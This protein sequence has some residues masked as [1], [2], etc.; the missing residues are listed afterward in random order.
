MSRSSIRVLRR[1]GAI[2]ALV[3]SLVA[4]PSVAQASPSASDPASAPS[5][6][7]SATSPAPAVQPT[8]TGSATGGRAPAPTSPAPGGPGDA[9]SPSDGAQDPAPSGWVGEGAER[10]YI[11]PK[12]RK[13]VVDEVREID[14]TIYVFDAKG[15]VPNGWA[16]SADGTVRYSTPTGVRLGWLSSGG[17][18]YYLDPGA[19]GARTTGLRD[20]AGARYFFDDE[21]RMATGWAQAPDGWYFFETSGAARSGWLAQSGAW[22]YLDPASSGRM[23]TGWRAIGGSWYFLRANG[24]MATGWLSQGATWYHLA[25]SGAMTTGWLSQGDVWYL[26]DP[27]GAMATGWRAIGGSWYFLRANGAMATGW[28]SQGATWYHL[29]PS[30]TMTTGWLSQ[31]G[32]W[33][34]LEGDGAMSTGWRVVSGS[35]NYFDRWSGRWVTDRASFQTDWDRAKSVYSPTNS[36]IVV[37]TAAPHCTSFYWGDGGWQPQND[38]PCSVGAP[39]TPT[40]KGTF[41][42]GSRGHSF[43]R[44]YTAYWWTQIFG[45]YLFHSTLYHEGTF[46]PLDPRLGLHISHG[47]IR[48]RIE[49]AHW[50]NRNIPSGTTVRIF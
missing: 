27:S 28:L 13:P 10:R 25:P 40:V 2:A 22:F 37:D 17:R 3:A 15:R 35:W 50:I 39:S 32:T 18:W 5:A 43:G 46:A 29:A 14:G 19:R 44:G 38:W 20:I 21:G 24:A 9:A 31:G 6:S 8:S 26:L 33:Y 4:A 11:D 34:H 12:T 30:G 16:A 41:S 42:I 36:L 47:C 23:A 48:M 45:D 1:A 7:D 49:D